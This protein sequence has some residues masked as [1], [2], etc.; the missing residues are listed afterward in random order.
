MANNCV[1]YRELVEESTQAT[2]RSIIP[3]Q[4]SCSPSYNAAP[5]RIINQIYK[6]VSIRL[7]RRDTCKRLTQNLVCIKVAM[8]SDDRVFS[9]TVETEI[10]ELEQSSALLV[11]DK[12]KKFSVAKILNGKTFKKVWEKCL[13]CWVATYIRFPDRVVLDQ[14]HQVQ[15]P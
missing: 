12:D 10:M 13:I 8:P 9:R 2:G 11:V 15:S 3:L 6:K 4:T 1:L 14:G 5:S 7:K